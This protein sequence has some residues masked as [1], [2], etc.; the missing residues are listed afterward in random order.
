MTSSLVIAVDCSTTAAKAIIVD[1]D[2]RAAWA[3]SF[4]DSSSAPKEPK[5]NRKPRRAR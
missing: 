4:L 5:E 2:P 1:A 3:K